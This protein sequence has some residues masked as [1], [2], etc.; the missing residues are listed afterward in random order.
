MV[1]F[2]KKT[3]MLLPS[4]VVET[5]KVV[6]SKTAMPSPN[7]PLV[8]KSVPVDA[9]TAQIK[10][11]EEKL[12]SIE[13]KL[14]EKDTQMQHVAQ[15]KDSLLRMI[16]TMRDVTH[17][18]EV[19]PQQPSSIPVEIKN[20]KSKTAHIS[21]DWW[22]RYKHLSLVLM[23][24]FVLGGV[25]LWVCLKDARTSIDGQVIIKL[26][27]QSLEKTLDEQALLMNQYQQLIKGADF[28][29]A[30]S[31]ELLSWP[32]WAENMSMVMR[33]A[34]WFLAR[35]DEVSL[36]KGANSL[37]I[38]VSGHEDKQVK[39]RLERIKVLFK[40]KY[41]QIRL[42]KIKERQDFIRIRQRALQNDL[43]AVM[44]KI[45][46]LP[47]DDKRWYVSPQQ[48]LNLDEKVQ[49]Q[50][51]DLEKDL[52]ALKEQWQHVNS[53]VEK[54]MQDGFLVFLKKRSESD[55]AFEQALYLRLYHL[56]LRKFLLSETDRNAFEGGI[57][58]VKGQLSQWIS[59][60]SQVQGVHGGEEGIYIKWLFLNVRKEALMQMLNRLYVD[61]TTVPP[62]T[63]KNL[64]SQMDGVLRS[65]SDYDEINQRLLAVTAQD[66]TNEVI[67]E[68]TAIKRRA[69]GE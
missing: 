3:D 35:H 2:L 10:H 66:I 12:K 29:I 33:L 17:P 53:I 62:S 15:E 13:E 26:R 54:E 69:S 38:R 55:S 61:Y 9:L 36:A 23:A 32:E 45:N 42:E 64:L 1:R 40:T 24:I 56:E 52:A 47:A 51:L 48:K 67:M 60:I 57:R 5:P 19:L 37:I 11:L 8:E 65:L 68:L 44:K 46:A 31:R 27:P 21:W 7:P 18:P 20:K 39:L 41:A 50:A 34:A 22:V 6:L 49:V 43:V 4:P 63:Y 16:K 14:R 25:I 59:Q 30:L 58:E 28:G